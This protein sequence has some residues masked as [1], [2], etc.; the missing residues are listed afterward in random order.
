MAEVSIIIRAIDQ[1]S[2]VMGGIKGSVGGL[3]NAIE[4]HRAW[5]MKVGAV[6][7]GVL[8]GL[9]AIAIS[10]SKA[11]W[12]AQTAQNQLEHAVKNVSHATDEQL[13]ATMAL[14]DELERKGV[15]DGD[16]IKT[17]L[18]QLSTFGLTNDAVRGLGWSLAD[19]A[20]NQF[21]VNASGEQMSETANMIAKALNG[22]F[23]VLEKSGI[24]FSEAQKQAIQFGTEME[25]VK[26]INEGFAQNLKYTNE[27]ALKGMEGQMAKLKVQFWNIQEAIG[28][29][30]LPL[31]ARMAEIVTPL[32]SQIAAWVAE[33]SALVGNIM[34]VVGAVAALV[35][36]AS[37]VALI[38]PTI[39]AGIALLIWPV[40][41]VIGAIALLTAAFSTNFL[42][43]RDMVTSLYTAIATTLWP[44]LGA[45]WASLKSAVSEVFGFIKTVVDI[46]KT[47]WDQNFFG[48][49]QIVATTWE[50]IKNSTLFFLAG[51]TNAIGGALDI[52]G[53][54]FAAFTALLKGDWSGL[55]VAVQDI[56][57]WVVQVLGGLM[58]MG[59]STFMGFFRTFWEDIKTGF[60]SAFEWVKGIVTNIMNN[61]LLVIESTINSA[62]KIINQ[63]IAAVNKVS[64]KVWISL[65]SIAP[66][67]LG[68]KRA[69]GGT[70]W[71]NTPYLV[72]ENWPEYFVPG[73]TGTILNWWQAQASWMGGGM[74]VNVTIGSVRNDNDLQAILS[75]LKSELAR[76]LQLSKLWIP[77]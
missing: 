60:S 48:I 62:I 46:W 14:A 72:G 65:P 22:Q 50:L 20:V 57:G 16:N 51:L 55:W 19:L 3:T 33:N 56:W 71:W 11:A 76:S 23:G 64:G 39:I 44:Q 37:A 54:V 58:Q 32:V 49:Q 45:V 29:A 63:M 27:V 15:L 41:I 10:T 47:A 13:Q 21:G 36:G 2:A 9:A 42:G 77:A 70:V 17:G 75:E 59:L 69:S 38:L 25:K 5:L 53:W 68:W 43:I 18:A 4:T 31:I 1:A 52:I 8:G 26:A 12:E 66:V 67:S 34:L 35:A 74:V 61:I 7:T 73:R 28:G 6:A 24:R 30:F 40:G